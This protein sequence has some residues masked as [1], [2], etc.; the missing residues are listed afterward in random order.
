MKKTLADFQPLKPAEQELFECC[1]RGDIAIIGEER[2][3]EKIETNE[4]RAEFLRWLILFSKIDINPKGIQLYGAWISGI[5]NLD[6]AQFLNVLGFWKC[7]FEQKLSII[8][9]TIKDIY[10]DGSLCEQG[11]RAD[12]FRCHDLHLRNGFE[13]K[14]EVRFAGAKIKGNFDCTNAIFKSLDKKQKAL[15]CNGIYV[16]GHVF[17]RDGCSADG[18]VRFSGAK[19]KGNFSCLKATFKAFTEEEKALNFN[20][21]ILG[22]GLQLRDNCTI[23]NGK[24]DLIN[25]T[26]NVLDDKEFWEQ[27]TLK[28][29]YLDGFNYGHIYGDTSASFRLKNMLGK[30]S[31]FSPQPYKQLTKVLRNMGH[32]RDA[33]EVMIALHD[34]KLEFS[35]ESW[36][37]KVFRK[38]YKWTSEYGYRPMR[39]LKIMSGIWFL[40]GCIYWYGA[41]VTVFAPSNPLIFQKQDYNCTIDKNGTKW[42]ASPQDYNATNNWYKASPPEYTTFQPFWYSLDIILPVVDLKMEKD[43]GVVIPSPDG[44]FFTTFNY[45]IRF[46]TWSENIIGWILS[47]LLVAILSGLAKNE[48]E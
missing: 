48:K 22:G 46:L 3:T 24:V 39:I 31:E 33:D 28:T 25:L 27:V 8:R 18:T 19:I 20:G 12:G 34:K 35:K 13:A 2:P 43:W 15:D 36:L 7:V 37:Y 44:S 26:V 17:L 29:V 40:F 21:M 1:Q 9:T 4:I 30:V 45:F 11:I 32:D 14:A 41:N 10:M 16:D 42:F 23:L 6:N 38:I 47:L 5:L